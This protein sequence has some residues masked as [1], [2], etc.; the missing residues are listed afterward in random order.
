MISVDH[1]IGC[2][3]S[4]SPEITTKNGTE[5]SPCSTSI[6]SRWIVRMCPWDATRLIWAGV[7]LGNIFSIRDLVIGSPLGFKLHNIQPSCLIALLSSCHTA[8]P[9]HRLTF[10]KSVQAFNTRRFRTAFNKLILVLI[11]TKSKFIIE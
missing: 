7:N 9:N 1:T 5:I 11:Y 6:W 4:I 8:P 10:C 3:I 2:T